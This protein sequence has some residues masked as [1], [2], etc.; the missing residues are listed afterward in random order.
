MDK[1]TGGKTRKRIEWLDA[2]KLIACV[3]VFNGHFF[4]TF[5][6][7]CGV[8]TGFSW[9]LTWIMRN[10]LS[11]FFY[12][13]FWISAFC[14][15]SGYFAWKKEIRDVRSLVRA[16]LARY[17]RF[18]IPILGINLCVWAVD[19]LFGMQAVPFAQKYE[20]TWLSVFYVQPVT[21]KTA[22][23]S[24]FAMTQE[25]NGPYWMLRSLFAGTC[26]IYVMDYIR[27]K[28]ERG[29]SRAALRACM[30]AA[31]VVGVLAGTAC[32][33]YVFYAAVC[34]LGLLLEPLLEDGRVRRVMEK[35][36]AVLWWLVIP[37]VIFMVAKGR[38]AV[39]HRIPG[40]LALRRLFTAVHF[41]AFGSLLI[42]LAVSSLPWL[43]KQ[44]ERPAVRRAS[45]FSFPVY[46]I[47]WPVVCA[48]SIRLFESLWAG[49]A[50]TVTGTLRYFLVYGAT[51]ALI[52]VLCVLYLRSFDK[53]GAVVTAALMRWFDRLSAGEK[54]A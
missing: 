47:H 51:A 9:K 31:A 24:A 25:C 43:K 13:T 52:A 54:S 46:L 49:N 8:S 6:R 28:V 5:V 40:P 3:S 38:A 39:F 53:A 14:M 20:N 42:I 44:M 32:N 18:V 30:Y 33:D 2:I 16:V 11:I 36:P 27:W 34:P 48:F 35:I 10:A 23:V 19:R 45:V 21:L 12:G 17:L 29:T 15:I 41:N 37:A 7:Q 26:L 22:V 50:G 4:N 1:Q